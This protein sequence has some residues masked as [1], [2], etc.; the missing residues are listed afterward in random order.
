MEHLTLP[1]IDNRYILWPKGKFYISI[2]YYYRTAEQTPQFNSKNVN[3]PHFPGAI[4]VYDT[5]LPPTIT[6]GFKTPTHSHRQ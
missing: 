1:H 5:G 2:R 4:H 6:N 3:H